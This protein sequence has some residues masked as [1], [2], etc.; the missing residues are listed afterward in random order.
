MDTD[1]AGHSFSFL[2]QYVLQVCVCERG[3][4]RNRQ[5]MELN[6]GLIK[7]VD[8]T[9]IIGLITNNSEQAYL[10]QVE[11][12]AQWCQNN[13]LSLNIGKTKELVVDYRKRKSDHILMRI[14]V[15]PVE[16]VTSFR[17]LGIHITNDL[18]W[19]L[20]TH[21][22]LKNLRECTSF[23]CCKKSGVF[24]SILRSFY[25]LAVE[26]VS[27]GSITTWYGNSTTCNRRALGQA[28]NKYT[29]SL[30]GGHLLKKSEAESPKHHN[31]HVTSKQ[32]SVQVPEVRQT[33]QQSL[34][35]NCETNKKLFIRILNK[36]ASLWFKCF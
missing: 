3:K 33:P 9:A 30:P 21:P 13:N 17:Y 26:N 25:S 36:H 10:N 18:R 5:R 1:T 27:T 8:A 6:Q 11:N 32:W 31:E 14:N 29:S 16:R 15:E 12:L 28:H 2:V 7:F 23:E 22:A 4:D 24:T 35:Q 19:P 34:C 20:H